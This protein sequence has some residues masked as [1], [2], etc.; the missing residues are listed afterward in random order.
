[1]HA[2]AHILRDSWVTGGQS[3]GDLNKGIWAAPSFLFLFLLSPPAFPDLFASRISSQALR[4]C[5]AYEA[6]E[7]LRELLAADVQMCK[8]LSMSGEP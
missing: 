2:Q 4:V 7:G 1:M 5:G 8:N 3:H 6:A